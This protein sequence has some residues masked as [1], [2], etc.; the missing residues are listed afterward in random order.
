LISEEIK[1]RIAAGNKCF[2]SLGQTFGS[3]A[4]SNALKTKNKKGW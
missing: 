3:A 4:M 2:Y 1:S